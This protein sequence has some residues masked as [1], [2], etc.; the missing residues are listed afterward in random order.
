MDIIQTNGVRKT[1]FWS[2][3]SKYLPKRSV[4]AVL[5]P[6]LAI[7]AIGNT[8]C[9]SGCNSSCGTACATGCSDF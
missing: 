2:S 5:N 6:Q 9:E 3:G 1:N 8:E 7:K 4:Q